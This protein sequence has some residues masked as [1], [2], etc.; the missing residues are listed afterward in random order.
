MAGATAA[1]H[2]ED[3]SSSMDTSAF[4]SSERDI[5]EESFSL[6]LDYISYRLRNKFDQSQLVG[7]PRNF[8]IPKTP[9]TSEAKL[10]S[11]ASHME[12]EYPDL[13]ET[14]CAKLD[15]TPASARSTFY[16]VA[17]EIFQTGINWG[18]IVAL[19]TFGGVVAHHFVE[20]ERP[21]MVSHIVLWIPSFI[22]EHL[23]SWI[24]ENGGWNGFVKYFSESSQSMWKSIFAVGSFCAAGFTLLALSK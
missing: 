2:L 15:F 3:F 4:S 10:R 11:L 22:A 5:L 1:L 16:S 14:A 6:T 18:R 8:L 19:F 17:K 20:N 13:F 24:M 21:D 7:L 23:L 9:S 12:A